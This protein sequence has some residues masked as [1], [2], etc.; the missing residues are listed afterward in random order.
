MSQLKPGGNEISNTWWTRNA[1][2]LSVVLRVIFGIVWLTDGAMKF[3]WLAPA[4]V[5]NI[6]QTA[7]RASHP[8]SLLGSTS[9]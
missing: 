9:G 7:A 3:I 4:D 6:V 1:S 8:G 2:S 5:V